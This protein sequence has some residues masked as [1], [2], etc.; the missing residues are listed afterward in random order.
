MS[1][2]KRACLDF[3][4]ISVILV[5]VLKMSLNAFS[6]RHNQESYNAEGEIQSILTVEDMMR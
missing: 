1:P 5:T 3:L 2:L 4:L 6:S